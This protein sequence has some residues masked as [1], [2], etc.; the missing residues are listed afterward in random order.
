ML[1]LNAWILRIYNL[2]DDIA[3][4]VSR[5][6]LKEVIQTIKCIKEDKRTMMEYMTLLE[7]DEKNLK[8]DMIEKKEDRDNFIWNILFGFFSEFKF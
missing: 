2:R 4:K 3:S 1:I 7:R 5:R 8:K 6:L